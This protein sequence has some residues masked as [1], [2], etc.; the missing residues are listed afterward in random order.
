MIVL[1][2]IEKDFGRGKVLDAIDLRID[3]GESVAIVGESGAGK[4][5]LG[6]ILLRLQRPSAG[7]YTFDGQ[8]VFELSG[9]SLRAW[10]RQVQA[11]FQNP[12]ASLNPR[13]QIEWLITEPID[14]LDR[15]TSRER[16]SRAAEL[17][18]MVGLP[19]RIIHAYPHQLSGGQRQRVAIARAI[20]TKPR[21]I[22]LDE[23]VSSLDVSLKGQ[24]I[25]L[26][27]DLRETLHIAYAYITHD[28]ATVPY[29]CDRVYVLYRGLI[30]EQLKSRELAAHAE[31][32]YT[33]M[34]V[35][36]VLTIDQ[37]RPL[38][39]RKGSMDWLRPVAR[40]ACPFSPRCP[41]V[42]ETCRQAFPALR[43]IRSDWMSRCHF[44]RRMESHV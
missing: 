39:T 31:N 10:R 43:T 34:L 24:I 12:T 29:L 40:P 20:S 15:L 9:R 17:L 25:N 23:P 19:A 36:S 6:R 33:R 13:T 28:L 38:E 4:T 18:E 41:W 2:G 22:V 16:S 42:A 37:R 3:A 11:V 1:T 21:F 26:L 35:D 8:D 30:F 44:Q 5:T 7:T 32:P 14:L 27:K